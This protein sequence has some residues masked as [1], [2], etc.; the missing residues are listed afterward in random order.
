MNTAEDDDV[1]LLRATASLLTD[2]G[3][4][5]GRIVKVKKNDFREGHQQVRERDMGK[6]FALVSIHSY[7]HHKH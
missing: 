7:C 5:L 3:K 6:V 4:L 1:K 2:L